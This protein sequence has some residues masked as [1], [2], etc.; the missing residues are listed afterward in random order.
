[1]Q[2]A[3]ENDGEKKRCHKNKQSVAFYF[4]LGNL[5]EIRLI[6]SMQTSSGRPKWNRY[7]LVHSSLFV[8]K[9]LSEERTFSLDCGMND[10]NVGPH[11]HLG[12]F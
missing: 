9:N 4:P 11:K 2:N 12:Y 1:M 5:I 3:N 10:D 8:W 7:V 6:S